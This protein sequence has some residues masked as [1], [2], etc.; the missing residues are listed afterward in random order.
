MMILIKI[1]CFFGVKMI[2]DGF[3]SIKKRKNQ[4]GDGWMSGCREENKPEY[5][6]WTYELNK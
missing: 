1:G 5:N 3:F 4:N 2:T 6:K